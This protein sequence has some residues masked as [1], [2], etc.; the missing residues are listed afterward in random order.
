[1]KESVLKVIADSKTGRILGAQAVGLGPS[2]KFIDI[3]SMALLGRMDCETLGVADLAYAPPFSP[4]LS[5]VISAA[6]V[7]Q[8][9]LAKRFDWTTAAEVKQQMDS[10]RKDFVVLDVR[11][12]KEVKERRVP[13]STWVP[14]DQLE[15]NLGK[16]DKGKETAVHCHSGVRSYKAYLKLKHAGFEK[17]KNVDGGLLCW[18][19]E[20]E[21]SAGQN[22]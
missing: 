21:G 11:E 1:M 8:N 10:A 18:T 6:H 19:Y 5:P 12:E 14:L 17:V 4:A 20:L 15:K 3:V 9:K 22:P 7:L 2:D 13:G 16:L